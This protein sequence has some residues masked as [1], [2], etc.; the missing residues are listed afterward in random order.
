[1]LGTCAYIWESIINGVPTFEPNQTV[2]HTF[3]DTVA[4]CGMKVGLLH[5]LCHSFL[6][7]LTNVSLIH[8]SLI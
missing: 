7:F 8:D 5:L 2:Y 6:I 4:P 1:M 3:Q